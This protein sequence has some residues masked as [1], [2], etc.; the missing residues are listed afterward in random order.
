MTEPEPSDLGALIDKLLA[1]E[2]ERGRLRELLTLHLRLRD[3]S[4]AP[5]PLKPAPAPIP[6]TPPT[7]G[8][9]RRHGELQMAIL[10]ALREAPAK[11]PDLA[12]TLHANGEAVRQ[13]LYRLARAGTLTQTGRLFAL[14]EGA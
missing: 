4:E 3:A 8:R 11:A 2:Y 13:T 5:A 9:R 12:R 10:A 1:I 7:N 6:F 14:K